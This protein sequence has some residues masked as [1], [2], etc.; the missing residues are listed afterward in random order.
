M[1]NNY[2]YWEEKSSLSQVRVAPACGLIENFATGQEE[3]I[4]AGG[5]NGQGYLQSV[6]VYCVP[7]DS[8]RSGTPLPHGIGFPSYLPFEDSFIIIGGRHSSPLDT[9]YKVCN[10]LFGSI[11]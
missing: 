10:I 9:I 8:W 5:S 1:T 11:E 6:E 7:D 2:T 3:V 4:V